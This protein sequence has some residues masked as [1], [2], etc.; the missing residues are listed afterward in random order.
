V[1]NG[2]LGKLEI[3]DNG[4]GISREDL[5]LAAQRHATSKLHSTDD[6]DTL[7][8]F[9]FRG[10]ALASMSI[11]ARLRIVSRT[12]AKIPSAFMQTYQDG[13]P[14]LPKPTPCAGKQG[15]TVTVSDLFY[16]MPHRRKLK[17]SEE[18]HKVLTV[19]QYYAV[20]YPGVGFVCR[21][22]QGAK[23]VIDLNTSNLPPV[24][25]LQR[26]R[27]EGKEA[28]QLEDNATKDV[29]I[30]VFGS[31]IK[32]HLVKFACDSKDVF[33]Y[34]CRGF[35]TDPSYSAS[36]STKLLLFINHRW[37]EC[38]PLK[39]ALELLY[40]EF[41]KTKPLIYLSLQLPGNEVDVNVHPTK[42]QVTLLY[43][44]EIF[45]HICSA[46]KELLL[47][48]GH[49]FKEASVLPN[50]YKRKQPE[51]EESDSLDPPNSSSVSFH[52]PSFSQTV[53][54]SPP[55]NKIRTS[56]AAPA[57]ALEPYLVLRSNEKTTVE[58]ESACSMSKEMDLT[59]PGA[60]ALKCTCVAVIRKLRFPQ[61]RPPKLLPTECAY[62][63]IRSLRSQ[64]VKR[65]CPI[66]KEQF[67]K[68]AIFVGVLSN[69]RSLVQC[70]MELQCW[71]H[72][73]LAELL[74]QQLALIRFGG[75]QMALFKK[76]VDVESVIGFSL[77]LE[78][79]MSSGIDEPNAAEMSE[80]NQD[81]ARQAATCLLDR[82]K[83]LEEYFS[84]GIEKE[85]EKILLIG[86]PILLEG[87]VP[88]LS[89]L[90]LFLLRLATEVDY[91]DEKPCFNA[92]CREL[93]LFYGQVPE[94][95]V[96]HK[97]FPALCQMVMPHKDMPHDGTLS[98]LT[99]LRSLYK[100]FER[101]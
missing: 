7:S 88:Q 51:V 100:V 23:Q 34:D 64:L 20:Q 49:T 6:F 16:N 45:L 36:H 41:A 93:G 99:D 95:D 10:E 17:E 58:H 60:F 57:G 78:E 30:N 94:K 42:K 21:R 92:V 32:S 86:M 22:S 82:R 67:R 90:P 27:K 53:K 66:L 62:K 39:K 48:I 2:G 79:Q 80:T 96:Q 19:V 85:E 87:Y 74:F 71:H 38:T 13:K 11:V 43:Q 46:M 18:Y 69:Q 77:E 5:G 70:G 61:V 84:I 52:P 55:S 25:T 76:P 54:K 35:M 44:D 63:S 65:S 83:M 50:P 26:A 1:E 47:S 9:G 40:A 33:T 72:G 15:T 101:V 68:D 56:K 91:Q 31:S 8:S 97:V 24:Q 3:I 12:P 98:K 28:I 75:T 89:G 59:Q 81:L 14:L 37:V 4:C 73:K 29:M